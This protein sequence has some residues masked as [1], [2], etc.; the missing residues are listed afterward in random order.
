MFSFFRC[1]ECLLREKLLVKL[2]ATLTNLPRLQ[3]LDLSY[4]KITG[5]SAMACCQFLLNSHGSLIE[6]SLRDCELA[7]DVF[8]RHSDLFERGLARQTGLQSLSLACNQ[9]DGEAVNVIRNSIALSKVSGIVA[10]APSGTTT[11]EAWCLDSLDLSYNLISGAQLRP[12]IDDLRVIA[13][14]RGRPALSLLDFS[15]NYVMVRERDE[16]K[17]SIKGVVKK[18]NMMVLN[19]TNVLAEHVA[20]M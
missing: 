18:L 12:L 13:E 5:E 9:L 8:A 6:L 7:R 1:R 15:G 14:E 4:N 20:Q 3:R 19:Y 16:L 10:G 17:D 11:S 2:F